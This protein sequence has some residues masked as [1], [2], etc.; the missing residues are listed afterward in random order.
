MRWEEDAALPPSVRQT[1]ERSNPS[2]SEKWSNEVFGKTTLE[3]RTSF[4]QD[5]RSLECPY[6]Q[7]FHKF[8]RNLRLLL[9]GRR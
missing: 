5:I 4:R 2:L 3:C 7:F 1:S 9:W 8:Q 6:L